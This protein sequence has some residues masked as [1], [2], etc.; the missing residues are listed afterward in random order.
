MTFGVALEVLRKQ[1]NCWDKITE[2]SA[3]CEECECHVDASNLVEAV[4]TVL[5]TF[6]NCSELPNGSGDL[7]SRQDALSLL[8]EVSYLKEHPITAIVWEEWIKSLPS[9]QAEQKWIPCSE[10]MPEEDHWLGGSGKQF[11]ENVL[12]TIVN[13][14][15]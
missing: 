12:V 10:R 4:R 1:S 5:D 6:G 8:N 11:S 9:V 3:K 14:D 15:D 2:C 7:I 13:H